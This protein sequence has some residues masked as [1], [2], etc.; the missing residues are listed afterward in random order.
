MVVTKIFM[1]II[2]MLTS[3]PDSPAAIS[4]GLFPT[5]QACALG[6]AKL[7]A[8]KVP[9]ELVAFDAKCVEFDPKL[10]GKYAI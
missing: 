7:L 2:Y 8:S 10:V 6:M 3:N 5:Q 1:L 9:D 4:S